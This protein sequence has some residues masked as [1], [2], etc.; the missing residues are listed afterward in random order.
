MKIKLFGRN[1]EV[2]SRKVKKL[3]EELKLNKEIILV[4][5]NGEI[6]LEDEAFSEKDDV[7][8]IKV[9]SGG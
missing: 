5:K 7:R 8:I 1:K 3:I 6:V 2:S 9:I 4:V